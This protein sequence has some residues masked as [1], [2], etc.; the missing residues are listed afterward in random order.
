[1]T[2]S[3]YLDHD[4]YAVALVPL[5]ARLVGAVRYEGRTGSRA[6]FDQLRRIQPPT[7]VHPAEA[8]ACVL[9]AMVDVDR[10]PQ[11]LLAWLDPAN[12]NSYG[13]SR[14]APDAAADDDEGPA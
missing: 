4:Q 5:A 14:L 2:H 6:L 12:P 9:A 11:E 3:S 1:M 7:G 13:P 10:S 8:L